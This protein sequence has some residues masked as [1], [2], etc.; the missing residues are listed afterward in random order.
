MK[1]DILKFNRVHFF[2]TIFINVTLKDFFVYHGVHMHILNATKN[3]LPHILNR[4]TLI[5][6]L[7]VR[8]ARFEYNHCFYKT[9]HVHLHIL[10]TPIM[11]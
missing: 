4:T 11:C 9:I 6:K 2:H 7:K 3:V 10:H 5:L 8:S 1:S